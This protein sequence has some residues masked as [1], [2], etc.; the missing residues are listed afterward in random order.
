VKLLSYS[1]PTNSHHLSIKHSTCK[2]LKTGGRESRS[3][4]HIAFVTMNIL[5]CCILWV[6]LGEYRYFFIYI[7][8]CA[9]A[10]ACVCVCVCACVRVRVRMRMRMR[11][12]VCVL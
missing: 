5:A 10:Y 8:V 4:A 2:Q 9:N 11:V 7:G 1:I 6:I 3:F 12:C